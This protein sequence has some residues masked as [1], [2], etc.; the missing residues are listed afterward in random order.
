MSSKRVIWLKINTREPRCFNLWQTE[1]N[2][3]EIKHRR[4]IRITR[5]YFGSSLSSTVNLL[6]ANQRRS[7]QFER[8]GAHDT[9]ER[10]RVGDD[11]RVGRVR[12]AGLGAVK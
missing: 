1:S 11:V 10:P 8:D 7:E 4:K 12:R 2:H 5:R 9:N 3:Y 6:R